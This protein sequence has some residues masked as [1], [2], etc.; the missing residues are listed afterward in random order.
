MIQIS[1]LL[2]GFFL[3][4]KIYINK[5]NY[6]SLLWVIIAM[7]LVNGM[8]VITNFPLTM[9]IGR[10]LVFSLLFTHLYQWKRTKRNWDFFPL[11]T[12][13][14]ITILGSFLIGVLDPRLSLFDKFYSPFRDM[15][16]S[17][18]ILFLGYLSVSNSKDI[19]RLAKPIFYTII[20]VGCYG[21]FNFVSR[22]N[23][24][25]EFVVNFFF[26]GGEAD[27]N[28]KLKVLDSGNERFRSASTF[29]KT[30]NYGYVSSLIALFF[31]FLS[32]VVSKNKKWIYIG[33]CF[34]LIGIVLC[35]SRTVLLAG[36]I[37][38]FLFIILSFRIG[39]VFA[40]GFAFIL[41]GII[42]YFSFSAVE[43][44][45]NNVLDIFI[46]GGEKTSG[47]NVSMRQTQTLGAFNYF[48][49]QPIRGNGY[50]YINKELGWG[51]RD[52][53]VLDS[54]MYGFESIIYVWLIEQGSI[55]LLTKLTFFISIGAYL[56]SARKNNNKKIAGLGLAILSLFLMFSIGTGALGAWPLTML[57]LGSIIKTIQLNKRKQQREIYHS[58]SRI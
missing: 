21:V 23:L 12:V 55:G 7:M 33:L 54:D 22:S 49:Q 51:D 50:D 56:I 30:F 40:G 38:I 4:Y 35:F 52:N 25:Y 43:D 20:F 5:G 24:Y 1:V 41:I 19:Y 11:R 6:I 15:T 34:S 8:I 9:P 17:Y 53:A 28:T 18:L 2:L 44:S 48:L 29:D 27:L 39:K 3:S 58:N 16:E 10:W 37:A 14:M 36:L 31:L 46:T 47:S 57:L 32:G 26:Q 45:V 13:M 42:S